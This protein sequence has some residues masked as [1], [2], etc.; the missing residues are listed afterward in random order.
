M[1]ATGS[2]DGIVKL[3]LLSS[4]C[5]SVRCVATLDENNGNS[6]SVHSV[7]F[8]PTEPILATCYSSD[9]VILWRISSDQSSATCA[10]TLEDVCGQLMCSSVYSVAFHPNAPI[11]ATGCDG[12]TARMW[13]LSSDYSSAT[14]VATLAHGGWNEYVHSVAFHPTAPILATG[15]SGK[16]VKLW[17]LSSA[18]PGGLDYSLQ[19]RYSSSL[20]FLI[21]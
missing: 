8:H 2:D 15:S 18:W 5:T 1:L 7:A 6:G 12:G 19:H 20:S 3:F 13:I 11:L 4:D 14:C 9:K 17:R 10:A 21:E 16:S